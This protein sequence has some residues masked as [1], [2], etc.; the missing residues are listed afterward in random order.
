MNT[1]S[2]I[3][4]AVPTAPV[5]SAPIP[6]SDVSASPVPAPAPLH[7]EPVQIQ[8]SS[9]AQIAAEVYPLGTD[10]S[11]MLKDATGN[12]IERKVNANTGQITYTPAP[13]YVKPTAVNLN[14]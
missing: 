11:V 7:A 4:L 3:S 12:L 14:V 10:R 2:T 9:P 6:T 1:I 13:Q 5:P 8:L